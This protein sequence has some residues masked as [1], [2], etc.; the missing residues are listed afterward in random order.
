MRALEL[1]KS[2]WKNSEIAEAL[3]VSR[4]TVTYW[5]KQGDTQEAMKEKNRSGRPSKITAEQK[6]ELKNMLLEGAQAHGFEGDRWIRKRVKQLIEEKFNVKYELTQ[7]GVILAEMNM[8][9]QK[10]IKKAVQR[11]EEK[12]TQWKEERWPELKKK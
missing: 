9:W 7:V 1:K 6:M 4:P 12:I 2:G 3:G 10:P 5:F 11:D 8:T